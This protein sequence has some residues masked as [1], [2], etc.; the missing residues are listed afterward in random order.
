MRRMLRLVFLW[1]CIDVDLWHG[2][3]LEMVFALV[4]YSAGY[5]RGKGTEI[6]AWSYIY[7]CIDIYTPTALMICDACTRGLKNQVTATWRVY[8]C[9]LNALYKTV[10]ASQCNVTPH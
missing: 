10:L 8:T 3:V 5:A 2:Q 6:L 9:L 4:Q 7:L 1:L